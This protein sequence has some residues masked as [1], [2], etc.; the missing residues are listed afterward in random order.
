M[1]TGFNLIPG[2]PFGITTLHALV[3][4]CNRMWSAMVYLSKG[5]LNCTVTLTLTENAATTTFADKRLS[6]SSVVLFDPKT[7]NA[8]TELYGATMYVLTANRG[9]ESW[10]ITHANN[11]QTDRTFEVAIIGG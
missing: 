11:A 1:A 5:K 3:A 9:N 2:S 8:A 10:T 6:P 7:A 4:W